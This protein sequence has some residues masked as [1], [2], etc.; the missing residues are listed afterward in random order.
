MKL[1]E[2]LR[3]LLLEDETAL[4][5]MLAA[6]LELRRGQQV[7]ATNLLDQVRSPRATAPVDHRMLLRLCRA[8]LAIADGDRRRALAEARAGLTELGKARDRMGGLEMV[9]G[10]AI[11]GLQLGELAIRLVLAGRTDARRLF[12]WLERT[13]GQV[14][15]YEPVPHSTD[16]RIAERIGEIRQLR[17]V[18][19]LERLAGRTA[20]KQ[21][22]QVA[23]LER[24]AVRQGWYASSWGKPRPVVKLGEVAD[25]LGDRALISFAISGDDL[26]AVVVAGRR[27]RLVRLG[28]A[29]AAIE[30]ARRLHADLDA[31]APDGLPA[32]IAEVVAGSAARGAAAIDRQ[33]AALWTLAGGRELVV[34]PTGP[35][36]AVPWGVLP[37]LR[38]TPVVV[39]PSATAWLTAA[40]ASEPDG[41]ALLVTGPSLSPLIAEGNQLDGVYPGAVWL[42]GPD[43]TSAAV[44]EAMDGAR[45]AHLAAHGE[46]EPANALFSRLQLADGPMFAH[47]LS[48]LRRPPGQVVLA[49]CE[50]ALN[51]VRPGDEALGFAGALLAG[52]VRTVV[53]AVSRVGDAAA[54][55]AMVRYHELVAAGTSPASA[56][57]T[58]IAVDPLRRPFICMGAG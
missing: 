52:G 51:H 7:A 43:A 3:G 33:L 40:Q 26:V 37:S 50:L 28:S 46:H 56:L 19:Q 24:D 15:R 38:G 47:E 12:G 35:L 48:Q 2:T 14:Y 9:C 8:E 58:A 4:A 53:A 32:P 10:T 20:R 44:L 17:R 22:A 42:A 27:T 16:E 1:A 57:A 13:R 39:A 45:I 23:V 54:A 29:A 11:H 36:Y 49:A 6:R 41:P 55:A 30:A 34:V 31:L 25:A 5:L 21:S 18:V